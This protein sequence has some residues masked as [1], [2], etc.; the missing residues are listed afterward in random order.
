MNE[1]DRLSMR[2]VGVGQQIKVRHKLLS[3]SQVFKFDSLVG[4]LNFWG[5]VNSVFQINS[6]L[7][8]HKIA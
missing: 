4:Y 2:F 8:N 5:L 3:V 1:A 7:K 6:I